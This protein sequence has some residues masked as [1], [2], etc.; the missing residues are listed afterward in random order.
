MKIFENY[1]TA[2]QKYGEEIV[3]K[4]SK[5]GIPSKY[6]LSAC[7][8]FKEGVGSENLKNY[9]RQWM[10]YVVKNNRNIDVNKLTFKQFYQT[11]QKYKFAYGVPNKVYSDAHVAIGKINSAKDIAKFPIK[12]IWCISQ[13]GK[14]R[15]YINDGFSFYIIDNG[16]TSDYVRYVVLMID[17]K[18]NKYYWDLDNEQMTPNSVSEFQSTLTQGAI[19]FI[20]NLT[21]NICQIQV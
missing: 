6:L 8:F 5:I 19:S 4:L 13:P 17:K 15:K 10:T 7:R 12:N 9:F 1:N 18:G 16:D 11:V 21:E 2:K 20:Q 14:Y 3:E